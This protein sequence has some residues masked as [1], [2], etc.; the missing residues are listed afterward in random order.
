MKFQKAPP[1]LPERGERC[2]LRGSPSATG[3]LAKYDPASQWSTVEW[4]DGVNAP[5]VVHRFE[6]RRADA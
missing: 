1:D 4:D 6:L 3:M 2:C 5:K